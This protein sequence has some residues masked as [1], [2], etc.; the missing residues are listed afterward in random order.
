MDIAFVLPQEGSR[1][2]GGFKVVYEYANG[3][4]RRG[5]TVHVVHVAWLL[6]SGI[7]AGVRDYSRIFRYIPFALRG[8]WRPDPWFRLDPQVRLTWVPSLSRIFLPRADAYVATWWATAERLAAMRDLPGRKLY[9][10]QHLETFFGSEQQVMATWRAPLEK[11]VIARWLEKVARDLGESCQYI[12]NGLDFSRFGLDTPPAD[13]N[14]LRVA[15]LFNDALVWKGSAD[16]LGAIL[17]LKE[18]YPE[19]QA[20]FFSINDRPA[21]LPAWIEYRRTPPQDELRRIYNRAAIFL[22]PSHSEGWGLPA[23]EA[24]MCGAA[25]AATDI[26]G[27]QE[28]CIDGVTALLAPARD[29]A[30][31]AAAAARLIED[32]ALRLRL[33]ANAH[34]EIQKFTWTA[35]I[36]A[37]EKVLQSPPGNGLS[38]GARRRR[39]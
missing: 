8:S 13:R 22:A 2:A 10:I 14:P 36:D 35:A 33:A 18:R 37:F 6:P 23:C 38:A 12:P 26:D 25:V 15:M 20:E 9:L 32:P 31:L 1:P 24:M 7:P 28:F 4:A 19:L 11:I 21:D 34:R 16:G 17:R 5:H 39:R 29:P 27:H 3:L 30:A